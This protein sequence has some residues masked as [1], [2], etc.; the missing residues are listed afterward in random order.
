MAEGDSFLDAKPDWW[1]DLVKFV[2]N[3]GGFVLGVVLSTIL[4][5]LFDGV[6]LVIGAMRTVLVGNDQWFGLA[7]LPGAVIT[8][9]LSAGS[10]IGLTVLRAIESMNGAITDVVGATGPFEVIIGTA[11][12]SVWILVAIAGLYGLVSTIS[13]VSTSSALSTLRGGFI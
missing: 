2:K 11:L 7:D 5:G 3:P 8:P 6:E 1:S 4:G 9:F 13:G 12:W 10:T